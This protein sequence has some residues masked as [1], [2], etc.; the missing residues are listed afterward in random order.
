MALLRGLLA[1]VAATAAAG[2][3][4]PI[5]GRYSGVTAQ[6]GRYAVISFDTSAGQV[7]RGQINWAARCTSGKTIVWGVD[8]PTLHLSRGAWSV[9]GSLTYPVPRSV[10]RAPGPVSGFFD[11]VENKGQFTSP[12][13]ATGTF[14]ETVTLSRRGRH[15]DT[16][17]TGTIRWNAGTFASGRASTL[18]VPAHARIAGLAYA[19][20][21]A[22]DFQWR[23][24]FTR[25]DP[26][27][28][29]S[30]ASCVNADQHGPVWFADV[31]VW[32]ESH[33]LRV[34][35][36]IPAGQYVLIDEPWSD[37]ST[38]EAPPFHARTDPGLRHCATATPIRTSLAYD[39]TVISP[40]GIG[41]T[42]SPMDFTMP[43]RDNMLGLPGVTHGR[44]V[45]YGRPVILGPLRRGVHTLNSVFEY[46]HDP[47]VALQY[48]LTVS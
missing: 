33:V 19:Q 22:R 2:A 27:S 46:G 15:I 32:S 28:G 34:T 25:Q 31:D 4:A 39:G 9:P 7:T 3:G 20:W 30:T 29:P 12:I 37:C 5:P 26:G 6:P 36:H 11:I 23:G 35:C 17:D 48:V 16:C 24:R 8:F 13:S 44:A 45:A 43:A 18:V 38:V 14:R 21:L 41:V 10:Y 47:V 40:A 1:A 42:T